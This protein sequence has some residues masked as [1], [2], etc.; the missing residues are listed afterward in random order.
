MDGVEERTGGTEITEIMCAKAKVFSNLVLHSPE[1]YSL[2]L[3][4]DRVPSLLKN[5]PV[6]LHFP[7]GQSQALI[8]ISLEPYLP[9]GTE[10][11]IYLTWKDFLIEKAIYYCC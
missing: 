10:I 5:F 9:N 2:N 1:V 4:S 6:T 8:C 3:K 11:Y 7:K